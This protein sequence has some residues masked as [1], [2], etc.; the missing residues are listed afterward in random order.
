MLNPAA[1]QQ[2]RGTD[3]RRLVGEQEPGEPERTER[4]ITLCLQAGRV[5]SSGYPPTRRS[6][7]TGVRTVS[8]YWHSR[9]GNLYALDAYLCACN[10]LHE[11]GVIDGAPASRCKA[12]DTTN[13]VCDRSEV[14]IPDLRPE[15]AVSKRA[16]NIIVRVADHCRAFN[17]DVLIRHS[18]VLYAQ[19]RLARGLEEPDLFTR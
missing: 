4:P 7:L 1:G 6:V 13:R 12:G 15:V 16:L 9:S 11:G 2:G 10:S 14:Q 5:Q 19:T 3:T 18:F 8:S 17:G